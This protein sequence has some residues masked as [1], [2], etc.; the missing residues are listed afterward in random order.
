MS[1]I[2]E[3]AEQSSLKIENDALKIENDALRAAVELLQ[4]QLKHAATTA[5]FECRENSANYECT[6][7][8]IISILESNYSLNLDHLKTEMSERDT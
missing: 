2:T 3:T 4:K 1:S 6:D 8:E 7:D 5:Y